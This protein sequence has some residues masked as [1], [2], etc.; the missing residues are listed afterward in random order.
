VRNLII[1]IILLAA[2]P[3][4]AGTLAPG[5]EA[6]IADRGDHEVIRV[7]VVMQDQP[8]VLG[9]DKSLRTQRAP[10]AE[11]H[12][13]VVAT[14]QGA[15]KRSQK[16]LLQ[17]LA[18]N[19]AAGGIVGYVPH[20][21]VNAVVVKGTVAAIRDLAGRAD[22]KTIE[23]DLEVELIAPV[24]VK[25]TA[26]PGQKDAQGFVVPGVQ[27]IGADRVW[28]ELG[29]DGT[30]VLVANM[31]SGVDGSH[32]AL[33][34]RWRGNSVPAGTAW[35]DQGG[36]GSPTFP[37]DLVGHGTHVMGTI[38][39]ATASDTMGVAPGAEWIATNA[40][41][42]SLEN[43]DNNVI[44]GFEWLA[45]PDGNPNTTDDVP[46]VCQNSWGVT[47]E[48]GYLACDSTW[49]SV[50]DN[51]EAAGVVVTFSAGN[52][53]P[54]PGSLRSPGNR[55][56]TP[57]NCF[58][59]GSTA[60]NPP[61]VVSSFS[62]R[63]P[64][65]CGGPYA[66]KPEIMAPGE[67]IYSCL[68]G[69]SYGLMDGTSMA[70]P[71]VAG[72]VALMRQAAPDLDVVTIKE[73]LMATAVDLGVPGE[74]NAYGHGMVDAYA[75]VSMVLGNVSTVSGVVTDGGTGLPVVG[76][77][78]HDLRGATQ[79]VTDGDGAYDFTILS[80]PTTLKV[81]SFGYV[82]QNL[83]VTLPGGA[84]FSQD[85]ALVAMALATVSG[86]VRGPAGSP[87]VGAT[88]SA[89]NT[90][91]APV[92][93][94]G[95]GFYTMTLP[96]GEAAYYDLMAMAPNLAY[97]I[98]FVGFQGSRTVDF[99]LPAIQSDGFESGDFAT[100]PW[101]R[102]GAA[103]FSVSGDQAHE[104][105][106]SAKTGAITHSQTTELALDYYLLAADTFSFWYKVDSEIAFDTLKLY[107]DGV[108][109]ET[110]SGA[111]DWSF[112]AAELPAGLHAIRWV[113][114]KDSSASSGAD[115]A[116]IDLVAFPGTGVQ[117][118]AAVTLDATVL[119]ASVDAGGTGATSLQLGNAGSFGLDYTVT[120]LQAESHLPTWIS[121]D[122]AAGL[123]YPGSIKTI[124][125]SFDVGYMAAGSHLADL[126][127]MSND[128]AHPDTTVSVEMTVLAV[129]PVG[130]GLPRH[131]SL[132][133]AVPNPFNPATDIHFSLPH[134]R[135][136]S[137][138]IY[139]VAG[140][141]VRTLIQREMAAGVHQERWDGRGEQGQG[142]ASGIYYARLQAG[143][144][145][146]IKPMTLVR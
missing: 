65:Q 35:L 123:L 140:R 20:W 69:N 40:I 98:Q 28:H 38:T 127:I 51:C 117:P 15:A 139:D 113:Y 114:A 77:V 95:A 76:A 8:D 86:I 66:I 62:S 144:A 45:D 88:V 31:D 27:A 26:V 109:E 142:V 37:N 18:A 82:E 60:I 42:S 106:L 75:A 70:G 44:A 5:L 129:S 4:S 84:P 96:A 100:L 11:R 68:P 32:P 72:V 145:S 79:T 12:T 30:G 128:P 10:L 43:L 89:L 63:G 108:L 132:Q 121:V 33:S 120:P 93:S 54:G 80:G 111:I 50:I 97:D 36:T 83:D 110:W 119:T 56:S 6:M 16:G 48:A 57:T 138:R 87:V 115:A 13:A 136:V 71:H 67:G 94:D 125:V 118:L 81:S 101:Q 73:V 124:T 102:S 112:Y 58:T 14:L 137:L 19:K 134:R 126:L 24:M 104:G 105:V 7:L 39:G 146:R 116:W 17:S 9:L 103:L 133:G 122:P 21:I 99:D 92:F 61:F 107:V 141:L 78:V 143:D 1:T 55:A 29:I 64:S 41:Y 91:V 130:D 47:T 131:L 3:V 46:D 74:D 59:I 90:P 135:P 53:G 85:V 49:W 25:A 22:V 23:P 52:E 2:A 34:S